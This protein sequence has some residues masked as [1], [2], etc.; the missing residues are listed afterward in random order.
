MLAVAVPCHRVLRNNG[1]I[2]GYRW[3]V[4]RKQALLARG[5]DGDVTTTTPSIQDRN[6]VL[7]WPAMTRD[8]DRFGCTIVRS[9]LTR[10]VSLDRRDV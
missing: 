10:G 1:G 2:S 5:K 4:E 6:V 8:L 9:V 7:D 3:G